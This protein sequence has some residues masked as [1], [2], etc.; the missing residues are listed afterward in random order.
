MPFV[1]SVAAA[2]TTFTTSG[3]PNTEVDHLRHNAGST[4]GRGCG[5]QA[6]YCI[7]KGAALTAI[8]GIAIRGKRW[9]TGSTVGTT[10]TPVGRAIS[11]PAASSTAAYGPTAGS[12]DGGYWLTIG[13]GAAGPGGWVAPNPDSVAQIENGSGDSLDLYSASGTA[14]LVLE[15][16]SEIVE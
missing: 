11:Q 7:G 5:V 9:T 13:C 12:V 3:T 1:Y 15:I 6:V 2:G 10:I 14:S 4:P 8:S 16:S